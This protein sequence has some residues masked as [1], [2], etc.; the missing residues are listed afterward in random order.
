MRANGCS[1]RGTCGTSRLSVTSRI[2]EC[3]GS[4]DSAAWVENGQ[5]QQRRTAVDAGRQHQPAGNGAGHEAQAGGVLLHVARA[6]G[7]IA[8]AQREAQLGVVA[9]GELVQ[10]AGARD[11]VAHLGKLR[12]AVDGVGEGLRLHRRIRRTRSR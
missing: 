1:L 3:A 8:G 11:L 5:A 7:R 10:L 9:A 4:S 6:P 12:R 2:A